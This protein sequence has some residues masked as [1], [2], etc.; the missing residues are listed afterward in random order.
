VSIR[1]ASLAHARVESLINKRAHDVVGCL[2]SAAINKLLFDRMT[3]TTLYRRLFS[4]ICLVNIERKTTKLNYPGKVWRLGNSFFSR[5]LISF[6]PVCYSRFLSPVS[7]QHFLRVLSLFKKNSSCR[8]ETRS[9]ESV[10]KHSHS[11]T[12]FHLSLIIACH[13][14]EFL[15]NSSRASDGEYGRSLISSLFSLPIHAVEVYS[16]SVQAAQRA[17]G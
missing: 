16:C 4:A 12:P 7:A 6:I 3:C 17:L 13:S 8:R 9:K 11:H 10:N 14:Y 5:F 2:P 15:P 1:R